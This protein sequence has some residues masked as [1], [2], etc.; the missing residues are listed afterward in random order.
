MELNN[1][2]FTLFL[3]FFAYFFSKYF[4]SILKESKSNLLADN[5]FQKPQAF[6]ED[7]T[8]RLGGVIIFSFLVFVFFYLYLFRN[9]FLS[10][11]VSFCTLFFLLGLVDDLK[12]N[13]APKFRLLI[14]I[15]FLVTLSIYN[16]FYIKNTGLEFLDNLIA[17]DVFS[18]MFICLC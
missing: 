18:L 6:H 4:F 11:Y 14:M 1:I 9:I 12:I 10:E 3:I 16:E 8:Y 7:T 2:I 17:I 13:I 5:Q 15:T